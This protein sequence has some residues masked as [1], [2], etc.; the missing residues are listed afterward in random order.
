MKSL[1]TTLFVFVAC[2]SSIA[3]G[4]T[5]LEVSVRYWH[6]L[7]SVYV[8][9]GGIGVTA[10]VDA[11]G[12][13][14][15]GETDA[16]GKF[17]ATVAEAV[18]ANGSVV[19]RAKAELP[20]RL[21][22]YSDPIALGP[23]EAASKPVAL[24]AGGA[25]AVELSIGGPDDNVADAR[26]GAKERI[27][28]AIHATVEMGAVWRW[29]KEDHGKTRIFPVRTVFFPSAVEFSTPEW[30][31]LRASDGGAWNPLAPSNPRHI[32]AHTLIE[33]VWAPSPKKVEAVG[34]HGESELSDP[35]EALREALATALDCLSL[36]KD[37]AWPKPSTRETPAETTLRILIAIAQGA[38][39]ATVNLGE[40]IPAASVK[41][42][43]LDPQLAKVWE[44]AA[45]HNPTVLHATEGDLEDSLLAFW[46]SQAD[47]GKV[48]EL[49]AILGRAGI[50][51]KT[52]PQNAPGVKILTVSKPKKFGRARKKADQKWRTTIEFEVAE[53]DAEDRP[54]VK[55]GLYFKELGEGKPWAKV[56]DG[57]WKGDAKSSATVVL[58]TH[59]RVGAYEEGEEFR[60]VVHDEMAA[61]SD[62]FKVPEKWEKKG[63]KP[64]EKGAAL[65]SLG[66]KVVEKTVLE[67]TAPEAIRERRRATG[68][69]VDRKDEPVAK[70]AVATAALVRL[71]ANA[72]ETTDAV[73][74]KIALAG[75]TTKQLS[76]SGGGAVATALDRARSARKTFWRVRSR[77]SWSESFTELVDRFKEVLF[78]NE[79]IPATDRAAT[80][81]GLGALDAA[82][83]KIVGEIKGVADTVRE[84]R[85]KFIEKETSE[86]IARANADVRKR[87]DEIVKA[88]TEA[89]SWI[90]SRVA[91]L[92]RD[93]EAARRALAGM[94]KAIKL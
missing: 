55:W 34:F 22:V 33:S 56:S 23:Y 72:H 81:D 3:R 28:E 7:K 40:G 50:A 65:T 57:G 15:S 75:A 61:A 90:A 8:P 93:L 37:C 51:L 17:S 69:F 89:R 84:L 20:T 1:T 30:F 83:E 13:N 27:A 59:E 76:K 60:V 74:R 2:G 85:A 35:G 21:T 88:L 91:G 71:F 38:P 54:F 39:D 45:E 9:A 73:I 18:L 12:L 82:A 41:L 32:Y 78:K 92:V 42:E 94:A 70:L 77:A 44:I 49:R 58:H 29:F 47:F 87:L 63:E 64:A 5:Q 6:P 80:R 31:G 10:E 11:L 62:S 66:D 16:S 36:G 24:V 48:H 46:L 68:L 79:W 43:G 26:F 19:V 86:R 14:P 52:H 4:E 67:R 53:V 25:T